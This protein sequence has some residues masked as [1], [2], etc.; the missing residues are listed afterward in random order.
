MCSRRFYECKE[1]CMELYGG[2]EPWG[3][4]LVICESRCARLC[5]KR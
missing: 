1:M 5:E 4:E 2:D 3:E